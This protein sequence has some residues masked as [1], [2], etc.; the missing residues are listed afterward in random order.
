MLG[1]S[2]YQIPDYLLAVEYLNKVKIE[3][4]E[5]VQITSYYLGKL[6]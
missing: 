2:Y 3:D 6:S 1:F 5:Q 4:N